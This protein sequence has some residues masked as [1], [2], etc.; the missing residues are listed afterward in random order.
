[1]QGTL[2]RSV[3][4]PEARQGRSAFAESP[5]GHGNGGMWYKPLP[6]ICAWQSLPVN[7]ALKPLPDNGT[8][9]GRVRE[10]AGCGERACVAVLSEAR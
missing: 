6:G 9:A 7:C 3:F 1:L 4:L 2:Q 10:L 5:G 8:A